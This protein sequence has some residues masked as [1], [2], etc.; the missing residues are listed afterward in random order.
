MKNTK[1]P[2]QGAKAV[3]NGKVLERAVHELL[4]VS[5]YRHVK[6]ASVGELLDKRESLYHD[7]GCFASQCQVPLRSPAHAGKGRVAEI[8]YV[9]LPASGEVVL[10]SLKSQQED[11]SADEKLAYETWQLLS[12]EYPAALLVF[13]PIKGVTGAK[14][15]RLQVLELVWDQARYDGGNRILLMRNL[16]KMARWIQDGLPVASGR[17]TASDIFAQYGDR[18]P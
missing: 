6:A 10:I 17:R 11:G 3:A 15:W 12:T 8:D 5:G 14:G 2:S 13:G 16:D 1:D 18:E 9:V 4:C 7:A